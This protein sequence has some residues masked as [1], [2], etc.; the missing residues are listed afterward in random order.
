MF[1]NYHKMLPCLTYIP[2]TVLL[3]LPWAEVEKAISKLDAMEGFPPWFSCAAGLSCP[4]TP[5]QALR[6][7]RGHLPTGFGAHVSVL[8][9][10]WATGTEDEFR[11]PCF[12]LGLCRAFP[13]FY[14]LSHIKLSV[15]LRNSLNRKASFQR[16]CQRN[17]NKTMSVYSLKGIAKG[18]LIL[19]SNFLLKASLNRFHRD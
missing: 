6:G 19:M 12:F 4:R 9:P 11:F 16:K 14:F 10:Q 18:R 1:S 13:T 7:S 8:P 3:L 5:Q 2:T 15:D 17:E